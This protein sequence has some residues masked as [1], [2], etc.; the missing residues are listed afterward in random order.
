MRKAFD[1]WKE[2]AVTAIVVLK[3]T[4]FII[5][6]I[7]S[8]VSPA[9]TVIFRGM[10]DLST[11]ATPTPKI[12]VTISM[13]M[14]L[15]ASG[16]VKNA[17]HLDQTD[18]TKPVAICEYDYAFPSPTVTLSLSLENGTALDSGTADSTLNGAVFTDSPP[19]SDISLCQPQPAAKYPV[20]GPLNMTLGALKNFAIPGGALMSFEPSPETFKNAAV[21]ALSSGDVNK[22]ILSALA[23]TAVEGIKWNTFGTN[24]DAKTG[25]L[26]LLPVTDA[27]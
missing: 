6:A 13:A 14:A 23:L 15:P 19:T 8:S 17:S 24:V 1:W 21:I 4:I 5:I 16:A 3:K 2:F 11:A 20:K 27:K 18:P 26:T 10:I 12:V 7:F 22:P 9:D 25:V